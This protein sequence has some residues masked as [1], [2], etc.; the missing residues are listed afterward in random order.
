MLFKRE[1]RGVS[2]E[3]RA[4]GLPNVD[5]REFLGGEKFAKG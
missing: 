5:F 3:C 1:E 2:N 4:P